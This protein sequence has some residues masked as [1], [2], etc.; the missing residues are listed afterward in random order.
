MH[1]GHLLKGPEEEEE[2]R[3]HVL[4]VDVKSSYIKP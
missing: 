3:W 1:P 2:E 4:D